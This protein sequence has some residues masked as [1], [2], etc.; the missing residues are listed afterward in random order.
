[1]ITFKQFILESGQSKRSVEPDGSQVWFYNAKLHRTDGPAVIR[2]DGTKEW[3]ING[4]LHRTDGPAITHPNGREEWYQ[5]YKRH[6]VGGPA[7][8]SSDG[9]KHWYQNGQRHNPDGP[10]IIYS[11]NGSGYETKAWFI[12]NKEMTEEDFN[13]W[14]WKHDQHEALKKASAETG[15]ELDI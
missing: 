9:V 10:A 1:M 4:Q 5:N 13:K 14:K 12:N 2:P 6:R 8:I 3:F 15:I 7:Y 11:P